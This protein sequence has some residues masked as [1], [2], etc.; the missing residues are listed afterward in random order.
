MSEREIRQH[1]P[2]RR[3]NEH[4]SEDEAQ[5]RFIASVKTGLNTNPKLIKSIT[6]KGVSVQSKKASV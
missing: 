3:D 1:R 6:P 2:T 5:R 4:Y